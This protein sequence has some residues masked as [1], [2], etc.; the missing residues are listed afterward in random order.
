MPKV[1]N[2][3]L[4]DAVIRLLCVP[5]LKGD[6]VGGT[7]MNMAFDQNV[8]HNLRWVIGNTMSVIA[9]DSFFDDIKRLVLDQTFGSSRQMYVLSLGKMKKHRRQSLC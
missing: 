8:T 7:L 1:T 2:D 9:D 4:K 5:W 6:P 3:G